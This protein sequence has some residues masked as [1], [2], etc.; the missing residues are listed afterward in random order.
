MCSPTH[1]AEAAQ[2]PRPVGTARGSPERSTDRK[3]RARADMPAL[4]TTELRSR[5]TYP[6]RFLRRPRKVTNQTPRPNAKLVAVSGSRRAARSGSTRTAVSLSRTRAK[7]RLR[8][9]RARSDSGSGQRAYGLAMASSQRHGTQTPLADALRRCL[10]LSERDRL[11]LH[12]QLGYY[13]AAAPANQP[14][15]PLDATLDRRRR[16]LNDLDLAARELRQRGQLG[17]AAA[18]TAGQYRTIS[19]Q[20]GL[21]SLSAVIRAFSLWR[22]ARQALVGEALPENEA[23]RRIRRTTAK[24]RATHLEPI[25]SLRIWLETRPASTT[26]RSFDAFVK[27]KNERLGPGEPLVA[28]SGVVSALCL[29]WPDVLGIARGE[30]THAQARQAAI[31]RLRRDAGPLGLISAIQVGLVLGRA[32]SEVPYLAG[33]GLPKHRALV[34]D[35]KAW[36][37][38][39]IEAWRE[40]KVLPGGSTTETQIELCGTEDVARRLG[41]TPASVRTAVNQERWKSVP[42][43]AGRIGQSYYWLREELNAWLTSPVR[44]AVERPSLER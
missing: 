28:A 29:P 15:S 33:R 13:L 22:Y 26:K 35:Q 23:R 3:C 16:A 2:L 43:P 18:P 10:E 8:A 11:E 20:L 40:G 44:S 24:R 36:S 37:L 5:L 30:K 4:A 12:A 31:A 34:G 25:A 38:D 21:M 6:A 14:P 9:N 17:P 19:G 27:R 41:M 7:R 32:H 42:R 1:R 39:D